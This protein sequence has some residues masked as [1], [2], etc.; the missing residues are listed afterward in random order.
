MFAVPGW[1]VSASKLKTQQEPTSEGNAHVSNGNGRLA[2]RE[3]QTKKRKRGHGKAHGVN[4]AQDNIAELWQKHIEGNNSIRTDGRDANMGKKGKRR[5]RNEKGNGAFDLRNDRQAQDP[6]DK[7]S[8]IKTALQEHNT[9]AKATKASTDSVVLPQ[10]GKAKYEQRKA[11]AQWKA[12]QRQLRTLP[13]SGPS[14]ELSASQ[15]EASPLAV[16]SLPTTASTITP[17]IPPPPPKAAKLT[18]LQAAMRAKLISARFRHLNQILYTTPSAQA[19]S[20]F[21]SDPEAYA[22]YHAGFRAQVASWPQNPVEIFIK[23]IMTRAVI[24]APSAQKQKRSKREGKKEHKEDNS[25]GATDLPATGN[26]KVDPLP[27]S[28]KTCTILDLGC[29]DAHLHASLLPHTPFLNL[30]IRSFDLSPGDTPNAYLV[31]VT[32]IAHLPLPDASTDI[33]IFCLALMGTNWVD[34]VAEAARV[35]REGGECWVGEVK[36]RFAAVREIENQTSK[37]DTSV[38]KKKKRRRG[39]DDNRVQQGGGPLRVEED[40]GLIGQKQDKSKV[41][42]TDVG[43]FVGVFQRRG[44]ALKGEV[45]TGNKMFVRMRFIRVRGSAPSNGIQAKRKPKESKF[46][47]KEDGVVMEPDAEAK[48]LKPCVYKSR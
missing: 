16:P 35:V 25:D 40:V 42:E 39:D 26:A 36:S 13:P 19:S 33:A 3:M 32:D 7:E 10:D 23:E 22:S 38:G 46:I 9:P 45:D 17:T 27:R 34:F 31:T 1:S 30:S 8:T 18:P 43:P 15:P 47:D 20:L 4:V 2:A 6:K 11:R 14:S 44:F 24:G 12:H 29:G 5:Q 28:G 21:S 41:Q 48:I 37:T